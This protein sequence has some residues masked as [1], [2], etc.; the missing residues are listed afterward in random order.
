MY[1][2]HFGLNALPFSIAPNPRYL[3]LTRQHQEALAHLVYGLNS[4]GMILLTGEVGTGKTTISRKLLEDIP[5]H[6]DIAWIVNPKLSAEELLATICDELAI[7]YPEHNHSIKIFT[8]LINAHLIDAHG[9]G[10]NVVLMIDEAQNLSAEVLE[11]LRLLTNLETNEHKLLQIVLLGQPELKTMLERTDLRQL[12]QR[13]TARYHLHPLNRHETTAYIRHRLAVAGCD[14]DVFSA[15]AMNMIHRISHGTPRLINLL[16]DRA[17]LGVYSSNAKMVRPK[18]IRQSCQ[19]VLGSAAVPKRPLFVPVTVMAL[20]LVTGAL[21]AS[22]AWKQ[23]PVNFASA[24]E[25]QS[26]PQSRQP[27]ATQPST[28][29][30]HAVAMQS[31]PESEQPVATQPSTESEQPAA[32]P[33]PQAS[34]QTTMPDVGP[35]TETTQTAALT[36]VPVVETKQDSTNETAVEPDRDAAANNRPETNPETNSSAVSQTARTPWDVIEKHGAMTAAFQT[37][38]GIWHTRL[39]ATTGDLCQQLSDPGLACLK[40]HANLWL[41]RAMNR[42]AIFQMIG[43]DKAAHYG[44]IRSV[45]HGYAIIQLGQQQ[46]RVS[47]SELKRHMQGQMT[48]IWFRPP[49]FHKDIQPGD[50]GEAVAWLA[51][52]LDRIQGTMIPARHV[53]AMDDLLVAR[54]KDFQ[55][56]QGLPAD[57]IAGVRT[58]MRINEQIGLAI[59]RLLQLTRR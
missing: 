53:E 16:C 50:R 56:S 35:A 6:I 31:P 45:S 55:A 29:P 3:Y 26:S 59:P 33:S 1:R 57:G 42:P 43:G 25:M 10:R 28:E 7:H 32:I 22:G 15:A 46:W 30:E 9:Q 23:L 40:Q 24:P 38:A 44:V 51:A 34:E 14:H 58:L 41:I 4:G 27:V 8:D 47:L 20:L 11:Q 18:H 12:A 39:T 13:I 5:E 54:L 2:E 49:G 19:E 36:P 37:L 17:M 48:L 21:V 52:Q